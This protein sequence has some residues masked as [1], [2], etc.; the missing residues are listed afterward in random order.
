MRCLLW[1]GGKVR[2]KENGKKEKGLLL[3]EEDFEGLK[4]GHSDMLQTS[5]Q[6]WLRCLHLTSPF[7]L[8]SAAYRLRSRHATWHLLITFCRRIIRN[9]Q[10]AKWSESFAW[11]LA[12]VYSD[13]L[14]TQPRSKHYFTNKT[15][16]ALKTELFPEKCTHISKA[17]FFNRMAPFRSLIDYC[18]WCIEV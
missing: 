11:N 15:N 4:F 6:T 3:F 12:A 16:P 18:Y 9:M 13:T 10:H 2:R 7:K 5:F 8:L 17:I 1:S 14:L